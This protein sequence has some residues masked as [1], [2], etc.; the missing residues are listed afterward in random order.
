M[1]KEWTVSE[2]IKETDELKD[3][4]F[5]QGSVSV[6]A[7]AGAGKTEFLA[8]KSNFLL[9]TAACK[10]PQRILC[11]TTKKEA[12]ENIK[13]RIMLRCGKNG[14][15]FDS[16][17]FDGFCKSILDRFKNVLPKDM[18]PQST[19]DIVFANK[20]SNDRDKLSF[21]RIREL[22][23]EII[24]LNFQVR[25][26]FTMSYSYIFIDEFQDTRHDQYQLLKMLFNPNDNVLIAVG[27]INQSIMLWA[28][29]SP[30]VFKDFIEDF[31]AIPKFLSNN[32]RS[33]QEIQG[34]LSSFISFIENKNDFKKVSQP[35]DSCSI[36]IYKDEYAEADGIFGLISELIRDGY[37]EKDICILT[38]QQS[39]Q[40]TNV[41]RNKLT[42]HNIKN[43]DLTDL[44]DS[45]KEPLG[46]I[47]SL[48]FKLMISKS[49]QAYNELCD[50]F[51]QI[52]N[53]SIG[54]ENEKLLTEFSNQILVNRDNIRDELNADSVIKSIKSI[55]SF[56]GFSKMTS[57]WNQYKSNAYV[58]SLWVKLERHLRYCIDSTSNY[59]SAVEFFTA[60]NCI[61]IMNVHKCKGLEYKAVIFLGLEDEAFW[62][63]DNKNFEDKCLL[64]V[65]LSRAKEKIYITSALNRESRVGRFRDERDSHYEKVKE[66]YDF[67]NLYCLIDIV[68]KTT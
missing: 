19:Y 41:L 45:L 68:D 36:Q 40:Y 33:N 8:Q 10:W 66:I 39:S 56:I 30:T 31:G 59:A 64:Y 26:L 28:K 54:D 61:Q 58:E 50:I 25:N 32:F 29:A 17:T 11:L 20:E 18:R 49:H 52:H 51:L 57:K 2:G 16:Y 5:F 12:Q 38:K 21:E 67:L 53:V 35:S 27:D 7:G 15:R 42:S 55:V 9:Q 62:K 6:L 24:H 48:A 13:N 34:I 47:F 63:Y 4:I 37:N 43:L 23:N 22:A 60:S 3:L 14:E 1:N 65:A 46:K 44:Q